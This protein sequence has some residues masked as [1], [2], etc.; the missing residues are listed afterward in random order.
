MKI[1]KNR[2]SLKKLTKAI[3]FF[4]IVTATISVQADFKVIAYFPASSGD[5]NTLA[6]DKMTHVNYSFLL[7]E[8]N[9]DLKAINDKKLRQLVTNAHAY[10]VKALIAVG[11][12]GKS[13]DEAFASLAENSNYRSNFV[14][15][16]INFVE[17]YNLDGV[18]MDWEFPNNEE[19]PNFKLLMQ[20]LD[21][22]LSARGKLLSAAV[23]KRDATNAFD[24]DV[25]AT[26]DY[27]NLMV[28]DQRPPPHSSYEA[29]ETAI[30]YWINVEGLPKEKVVLGV[31]FYSRINNDTLSYKKIIAEYGPSAAWVDNAGG[32]NYNGIPTI[33]AKT[34]LSLEQ[35]GGIMYWETSKDTTDDTSL[36]S[37]IWDVVSSDGKGRIIYPEWER[38]LQYYE[39]NIVKYQ[40]NYYIAEHDNPG[41]IPTE[42]TW[43][44]EFI[45]INNYPAWQSGQ[46]YEAGDI[47]EY[48]GQRYIATHDNPGYKPTVSTWYWEPK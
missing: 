7:P 18:D 14:S 21:V 44:W 48:N 31:P 9:G 26:V 29:A 34:E 20:E 19:V 27:L 45:E 38:N 36:M 6:Y 28:Y 8:P 42:S 24:T 11:G 25:I 30:S 13:T 46:R 5:A 41:Y 32:L 47:V 40:R 43:F 15:N 22:A 35:T 37:A 16:M 2:P 39:G 17:L 33:I 10:G 4:V 23:S 1:I 3:S 12:W